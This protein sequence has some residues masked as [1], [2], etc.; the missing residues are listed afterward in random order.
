MYNNKKDKEAADLMIND[1]CKNF[2]NTF[3]IYPQV[4][5]SISNDPLHKVGL[6]M[7]LDLINEMLI[8]ECSED[9]NLLPRVQKEGIQTIGRQHYLVL[10]RQCFM[11]IAND[12]G[13]GSTAVSRFLGW[14]HATVIY[15]SK[16]VQDL[17]DTK[18]PE[19]II[20]YTKIINAYKVRF[21]NDGDVQQ[22]SGEGLES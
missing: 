4:S 2:W 7:I 9:T 10:Y 22:N 13:Y 15:S 18:D 17:I 1:F 14:D 5:Y 21:N 19:T 3:H 16:K 12:L 11:K 8:D 6:H 20:I